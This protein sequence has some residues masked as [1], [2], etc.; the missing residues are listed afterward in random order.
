MDAAS[1]ITSPTAARYV[2]RLEEQGSALPALLDGRDEADL[3]RRPPA[4]GWSARE[5]IAHLARYH[6]VF[7]DRLARMLAEE[8]PRLDRYR[9]ED[10]PDFAPFLALSADEARRR[11]DELRQRLVRRV[12]RLRADELG[13]TGVH[14]AFGAMP[15]WLWLEFFLAH[16]GHHLYVIFQRARERGGR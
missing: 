4:G 10:D 14:P 6:E 2:A 3:E 7:L 12:A 1:P 11:F 13:R 8:S 5:Q 9:A 16:E 15:V